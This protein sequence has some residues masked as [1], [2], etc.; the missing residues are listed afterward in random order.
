VQFPVGA[1]PNVKAAV[2]VPAPAPSN[3]PLIRA[4]TADQ[5]VPLNNSVHV[6]V[7]GVYPPI[8]RAAV[9]VP[10]PAGA[11]LAVIIEVLAVHI[12]PIDAI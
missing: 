4:P 12:L 8:A 1:P 3:F 5:D 6:V 11:L 9:L 7:A 10:T 2:V